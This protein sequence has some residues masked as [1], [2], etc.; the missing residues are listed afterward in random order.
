[1]ELLDQ[2][3]FQIEEIARIYGVPAFMIGHTEKTTSWGTGVESMGV[4]FVRYTLR[5]HLNK[6]ETEINRKF[7]R[8]ASRVAKFDTTELEKADTQ[9]LFTA[10]RTGVGRSGEKQILSVNEAR[11]KLN[12]GS[13]SGGD[14]FSDGDPHALPDPAPSNPDPS[15]DGGS[16]A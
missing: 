12:L 14:D 3:K 2:R 9:A 4:S 10:L 5:P 16:N 6:F 7:F 11:R 1:M 13:I 8:T 15:N